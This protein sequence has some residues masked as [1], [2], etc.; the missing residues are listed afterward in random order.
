[1]NRLLSLA[2][3]FL[4]T[5][6]RAPLFAASQTLPLDAKGSSLTFVGD[7]TLHSFKGEAKEFTG[8]A[9]LDTE[10]TPPV[11]KATLRFKTA[12]LTTFNDKRDKNMRDWLKVEVHP[13]VTFTLE[14]VKLVEG[15][16]Q[17]ADLQHPAKF[18]VNG[19]L[20]LNGEKQPFGGP[21]AGWREKDRLIVT[22]DAVIDTLKFGLPQIRQAVLT[23]ATKVKTS[24]RFSF[25][26]PPAYT[27]K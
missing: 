13:D 1:M 11:Q 23:V 4:L 5:V 17:K 19:V 20:V 25:A 18:T 10:A 12:A 24:Y 7:A 9:T 21:A 6:G 14:N 2:L 22:G 27:L 3:L 16:I 8:S 26:L 15:D